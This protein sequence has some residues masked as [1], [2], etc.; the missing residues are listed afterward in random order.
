MKNKFMEQNAT[1]SIET[2]ASAGAVPALSH[3][4]LHSF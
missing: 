4:L 3:T 1:K 2:L